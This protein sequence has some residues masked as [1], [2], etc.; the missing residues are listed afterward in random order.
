[1]TTE[2]GLTREDDP[3]SVD[4]DSTGGNH[5]SAAELYRDLDT[6]GANTPG[7]GSGMRNVLPPT[8]KR[9]TTRIVH[10]ATAR[11]N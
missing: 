9:F 7:A 4:P 3:D 1:M 6:S 10:K 5:K 8:W 2:S 11:P